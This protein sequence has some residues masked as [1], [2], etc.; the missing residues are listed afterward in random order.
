[1]K[2]QVINFKRLFRIQVW[3]LIVLL[4]LLS[5]CSTNKESNPVVYNAVCAKSQK[6]INVR[7][8]KDIGQERED[9]KLQSCAIDEDNG[10]LYKLNS[11]DEVVVYDL[12]TK[13][14]LKN[15][16][17]KVNTGHDNDA[18][19]IKNK[20]YL[21]G[22]KP[23]SYLTEI[24]KLYC[25]NLLDNEIEKMEVEGIEAAEGQAVRCLM[26]VSEY[27]EEHLL[28][29]TQDYIVDET[30]GVNHQETDKLCI[31]DYSIATGSCEKIFETKWDAVFIQGATYID[32]YVFVAC[33][34]QT[35][36]HASN[37]KGIEIKI[38]SLE[39]Q[40]IVETI[41]INGHFEAEGLE[42]YRIDDEL[43]L[44]FGISNPGLVS[45]IVTMNIK[46]WNR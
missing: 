43:F 21:V 15:V 3:I 13:E 23:T 8:F 44:M 39:Q 34:I 10:F 28:L 27:I 30:H 33:N 4:G 7:L 17:K 40:S 5:S 20:M 38:I 24:Q 2:K 35:E 45:Q 11:T 42:H 9:F 32:G 14:F 31:Y 37:Y 22:S 16:K 18:C 26:G 36:K 19:I 29:V 41:H 1:M 25:W 46:E 12:W 6:E